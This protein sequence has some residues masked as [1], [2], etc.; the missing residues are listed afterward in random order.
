MKTALLNL[1]L[2]FSLTCSYS[3][4]VGGDKLTKN[5]EYGKPINQLNY[6]SIDVDRVFV[7]EIEKN[8]LDFEGKKKEILV[9]CE[10]K[11]GNESMKYVLGVYRD[12]DSRENIPIRQKN[13]LNDYYLQDDLISV[14]IEMWE[15]DKGENSKLLTMV[16]SLSDKFNSVYGGIGQQV[17]KITK[18]VIEVFNQI[19]DDDKILSMDIDFHI[20]RNE[21]D[22]AE[23]LKQ[24]RY[25][26]STAQYLVMDDPKVDS[27]KVIKN[28]RSKKS[29]L[30]VKE[31]FVP[32]GIDTS[33]VSKV[34]FSFVSAG[35]PNLSKYGFYAYED[36]ALVEL[37]KGRRMDQEGVERDLEKALDDINKVGNNIS[38]E[39][40]LS[41]F[42]YINVL[43]TL[44]YIQNR[45]FR[46]EEELSKN[47]LIELVESEYKI[48]IEQEKNLGYDAKQILDSYQYKNYLTSKNS[49]AT[50]LGDNKK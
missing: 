50:W 17:G 30:L 29:R 31:G 27:K 37:Q 22:Y 18:N 48:V 39:D 7:G 14:R 24:G 15:I 46:R 13:I 36:N 26:L 23:L 41:Q 43:R 47:E 5:I 1:I 20:A 38:E 2:I 35:R 25:A 4:E 6:L 9:T 16:E 44:S 10:I 12:I 3:Q 45:K 33:N 32:I 19:N 40:K 49:I 34:Y 42:N 28:K 21:S 11:I 8:F